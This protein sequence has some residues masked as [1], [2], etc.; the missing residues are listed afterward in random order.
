M[1]HTEKS[2]RRWGRKTT[3]VTKSVKQKMDSGE[4]DTTTTRSAKANNEG[5][6]QGKQNQ[7][8]DG[9]Q[10]PCARLSMV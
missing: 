7:A 10:S 4:T 5:E 9:G 6:K 8:G 1:V 2:R 3:A